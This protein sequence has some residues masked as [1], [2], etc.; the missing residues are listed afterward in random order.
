MILAAGLGTRLKNITQNMPK[1]LV[2]VN[3]QPMLKM[4]IDNLTKSGFHYIVVNVHHFS[5][6]IKDF[7]KNNKFDADIYISDE[8]HKLLDTGGGIK[9]AHRFFQDSESFLVHNVDIYSEV[10]LKDFYDSHIQ[11]ENLVSLA[12]RERK[13]SNYLLFDQNKH[14]SGWKSYKTNSEIITRPQ[15]KYTELAF[16]G[17]HVISPQIFSLFRDEEKFSII[18]EYLNLSNKN[19]IGAYIHNDAEILDLGKPE[20][21]KTF[22]KNYCK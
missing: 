21:I 14:L 19:N 17:I 12:V 11:S 4:I 3:G 9:Y 7:I 1:A 8:S 20:A 13:S 15:D 2:P 5:Q 16:S 22:E 10:D 18:N 6:Q